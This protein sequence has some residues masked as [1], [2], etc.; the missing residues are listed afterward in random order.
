MIKI[1]STQKQASSNTKGLCDLTREMK[2]YHEDLSSG[3]ITIIVA[4]ELFKEKEVTKIIKEIDNEGNEV[5]KEVIIVERLIIE[6]RQ[7]IPFIFSTS[8]IDTVFLSTGITISKTKSYTAQQNELKTIILIAQTKT[9]G[10]N[11]TG[12]QG[13]NDWVK[14]TPHEIVTE[15]TE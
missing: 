1:R 10:E 4:D 8:F 2:S 7:P 13:M 15:F 12:W 3:K 6:K 11:N 5:E 9:A 14:D